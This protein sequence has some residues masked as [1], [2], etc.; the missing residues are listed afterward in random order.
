MRGRL[1]ERLQQRVE[2][3]C[4]Q[5]VHLVDDVDLVASFGGRELHLLAQVAHLV[6]AAVRGRVDLEDVERRAVGDLRAA[7]A[8]AAGIGRRPLLA[9]QRLREN[10]RRARLARAAR[11]RKKIGMGDAAGRN[12]LGKRPRYSFLPHEILE[13]ARPPLPVERDVSHVFLLSWRR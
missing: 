8:D 5:H 1:F 3:L 7:L 11:P 12:R 10:L 6:D 9:V 4:R 2:R 13:S